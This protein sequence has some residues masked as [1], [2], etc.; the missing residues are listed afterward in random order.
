M[1][2]VYAKQQYVLMEDE[3]GQIAINNPEPL[4]RMSAAL[5]CIRGYL[6]LLSNY[7][8]KHPF[9]DWKEESHFFKVTK[10]RFYCH[11]IFEVALY[12]LISGRPCGDNEQ[13]RAYYLDELRFAVRS[14]REHPFLY[15]YYRLGAD[16]LDELYFVRN[17][18]VQSVLLPEVPE[19]DRSFST[20]GDYLFAKFKAY[21]MLQEYIAHELANIGKP[22]RS[23]FIRPGRNNE[24]LKW[25]GEQVNAIEM[26]YGLWLSGQLNDGNA[27]LA[28]IM[29]WL[30][31]SLDIDLSRH[32]RRFD[33][34][35]ARK[36]V[37]Q[38][39]FTDQVR[40]AIRNH[41]DEGNALQPNGFRRARRTDSKTG[42]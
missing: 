24:P 37:S 10:P 39:R 8:S 9:A 29:Y 35:K 16:E 41:I 36:L 3:L 34:I 31:A 40:D 32:T 13:L 23:P 6:D 12:N 27:S 5:R 1:L 11:Y 7:L 14:F 26:G 38:T 21:E 22:E 2:K 28:D 18:E 17:V 20:S 30:S 4:K 42:N 33:E 15:E 25:T 19:L